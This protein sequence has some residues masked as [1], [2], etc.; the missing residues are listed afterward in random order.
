MLKTAV[1]AIFIAFLLSPGQVE[2]SVGAQADRPN[3]MPLADKYGADIVNT[4][5]LGSDTTITVD[6]GRT[7]VMLVISVNRTADTVSMLSIPRDLYVYI[8]GW[9]MQRIN[10]AFGHGEHNGEGGAK[11]L[12]A[13]IEYNLGITIDHFARVDFNGF[14]QIVD[15]VGGVELSVDCAIQDWKLKQNDLDPKI[16]DNWEWFTLPVGVHHFDGY[17]ALWYV[18][19][20]HTSS[21][22]DRGRRQQAMLRALWNRIHA[23]GLTNQ[24]SELWPQVTEIVTTDLT[25]QDLIDLTPLA[26]SLDSSRIASYTFRQNVEVNGWT[27]PDGASVLL[28]VQA[29]I[30]V[31]MQR[32]LT[33]PTSS[34]IAQ[35]HPS[36]EIVNASGFR[37]FTQVA[38]DR[39]SV[40]GFTPV[41]NP[42]PAPTQTY[43]AI[44]DYTGSSKGTTLS[45]LKSILR[46]SDAGIVIQ[47][48]ANRKTDF[49]VVIGSAYKSCTYGVLPPKPPFNTDDGGTPVTP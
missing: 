42:Q 34:Q 25:A 17:L 6:A 5:L 48:D 22:F 39:L 40:E 49:R 10:T 43:N 7:D 44:F 32:F 1:F 41:V 26:L 2:T 35:E 28:P 8:P 21:D 31:L 16:E 9:E 29:A 18:R 4:L 37:D 20:R 33:P 47:P 23:L 24:I 38:Y 3:P 13:T 36:I 45:T 27:S 14:Q 19:S 30:G 46:V 12:E 15:D 11:L